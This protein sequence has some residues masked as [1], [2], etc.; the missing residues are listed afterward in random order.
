MA[1]DSSWDPARGMHVPFFLAKVVSRNCD[2]EHQIPAKPENERIQYTYRIFIDDSR[3]SHAVGTMNDVYIVI[4]A[5]ESTVYVRNASRWV[6]WTQSSMMYP[7]IDFCGLV[8][9]ARMFF[10]TESGTMW[11]AETQWRALNKTAVASQ[12]STI[13][14]AA[15]RNLRAKLGHPQNNAA[16]MSS[17]KSP[18]TGPSK[19]GIHIF[20]SFDVD[21]SLMLALS[22]RCYGTPCLVGT[23]GRG[24]GSSPRI[25]P[26]IR[27]S[28]AA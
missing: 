10:P 7:Q 12:I 20:L 27:E 8:H 3:P 1:F 19:K 11:H 16:P 17:V 15:V 5:Q 18:E 21:I 22:T 28:P 13:L 25:P 9:K 2:R 26:C 24:F 23:N 4:K 6:Q 14:A